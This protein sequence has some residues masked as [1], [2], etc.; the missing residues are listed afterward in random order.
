MHTLALLWV[1]GAPTDHRVLCC[2]RFLPR[3]LGVWALGG[4]LPPRTAL[5]LSPCRSVHTLLLP[6]PIEVA[7]CDQHGLILQMHA[8]LAEQR[9]VACRNARQAWEFRVGAT[10]RLG[11][12]VG[13]RLEVREVP[14]QRQRNTLGQG[15]LPA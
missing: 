10:L 1:D 6:R 15:R 9:A 13:R 5:C 4:R 8:P 2:G 3:L 7:F 11:L 14:G 12:A